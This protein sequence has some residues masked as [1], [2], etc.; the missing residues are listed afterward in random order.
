M[1]PS[2]PIKKLS[3]KA[4][5]IALEA[6]FNATLDRDHLPD[7]VSTQKQALFHHFQ[8]FQLGSGPIN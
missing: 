6:F 3:R 7:Q 1:N 2:R 5:P 8:Q 4:F